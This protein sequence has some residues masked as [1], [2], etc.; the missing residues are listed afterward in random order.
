MLIEAWLIIELVCN[1]VRAKSMYV[2]P[3]F[4]VV[5]LLLIEYRK[6]QQRNE[7]WTHFSHEM[8]VLCV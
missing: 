1:I 6:E 5:S 8:K 4:T 7:T 2:V 3:R